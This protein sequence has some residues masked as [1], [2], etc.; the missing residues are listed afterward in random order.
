MLRADCR[1]AD[2]N[3]FFPDKDEDTPEEY[4]TKERVALDMCR[5]C[6]VK[7]ECLDFAIRT[8]TVYGIF[9]GKTAKERNDDATHTR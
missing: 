1:N 4:D 6:P 3:V 2:P 7:Q 8:K 5:R 9:G